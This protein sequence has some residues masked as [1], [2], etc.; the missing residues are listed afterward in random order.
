MDQTSRWQRVDD[1][2]NQILQ[3]FE[4]YL[5]DP[6]YIPVERLF[7]MSGQYG[8]S[9]LRAFKTKFMKNYYN[10]P[11]RDRFEAFRLGSFIEPSGSMLLEF[12]D[13][14]G[15]I[16]ADDVRSS[17]RERISVLH[18]VAVALGRRLPD[19]TIPH[20]R[21]PYF[22]YRIYHEY[23]AELV[24]KVALH[25]GSKD[26]HV[27]EEITPW[28][29]DPVPVWR[30][31]PLTSVIGGTLCYLAPDYPF[32]YWDVV[33]QAS[34]QKWILQLQNA[35]VDLVSYGQEELRLLHDFDTGIKGAFDADA[36]RN[37]RTKLRKTLPASAEL[38]Q[39]SNR[40]VR[41]H[42][43]AKNDISWRPIRIIHLSFGPSVSDWHLDWAPEHEHHAKEF[44]QLFEE[45]ETIMPGSWYED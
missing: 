33:F 16:S 13:E 36:I 5:Q 6:E 40:H 35:G 9:S 10:R 31:T 39:F 25:C 19:E 4:S 23:W 27:L 26:L 37:S 3:L 44:W 17:T 21:P 28:D 2:A 34:L 29:R 41:E 43:M 14:K 38:E 32:Y 45:P 12:L 18:S 15:V 24:G 30:G 1:P 8:Q 11:A 22:Q 42:E 7:D 20:R